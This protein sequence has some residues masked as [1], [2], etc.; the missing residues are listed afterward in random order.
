[1][2]R[3]PAALRFASDA[4]YAIYLYHLFFVYPVLRAAPPVATTGER[5]LVELCAW[6]GGL[7]GPAL[8][9]LLA[10]RPLGVRARIWLGA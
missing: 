9:V 6:A 8:L 2:R 3:S 7:V 1:M 10:R 5:L 4:T